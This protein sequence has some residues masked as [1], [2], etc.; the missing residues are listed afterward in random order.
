MFSGRNIILMCVYMQKICVY[1]LGCVCQESWRLWIHV[2]MNRDNQSITCR[3]FSFRFLPAGGTW[4]SLESL[5]RHLNNLDNGNYHICTIHYLLFFH[6][7]SSMMCTYSLET[8]S[9]T[10]RSKTIFEKK[11][12][13]VIVLNEYKVSVGVRQI[14]ID[15]FVL[16]V[17]FMND[18][19]QQS[20]TLERITWNQLMV[21]FSANP[22]SLRLW[23]KKWKKHGTCPKVKLATWFKWLSF[24][25]R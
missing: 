8:I 7:F 13:W 1:V 24:N 18:Y 12:C 22:T 19:R 4:S 11:T 6:V 5:W 25:R 16:G 14:I 3:V 23:Q 20:F 15:C 21:G 9:N 17:C 2:F 10:K